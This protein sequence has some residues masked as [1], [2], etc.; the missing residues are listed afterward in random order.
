MTTFSL[1]PISRLQGGS[2]ARMVWL[3]MPD[4]AVFSVDKDSKIT[5]WSGGAD[6]L[7]GFS[8][9]QLEDKI[10]LSRNCCSQVLVARVY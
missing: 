7:L 1:P 4:A 2:L 5:Y 6:N 8:K 10:F 3:L 9:Q